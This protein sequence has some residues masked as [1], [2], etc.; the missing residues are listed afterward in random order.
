MSMEMSM[1][2]KIK[3]LN[4]KKTQLSIE[5]KKIDEEETTLQ[6]LVRK[7]KEMLYFSKGIC[8]SCRYNK[9]SEDDIKYK[10]IYCREC[11]ECDSGLD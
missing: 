9:L 7:N 6:A 3:Y 2:Q 8:Y 11:R 4:E 10:T 5:M 1:E